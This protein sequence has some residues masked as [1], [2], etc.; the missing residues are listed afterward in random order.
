MH[1]YCTQTIMN[2][3]FFCVTVE[4]LSN[5]SSDINKNFIAKIILSITFATK[6]VNLIYY[7][8]YTSLCTDNC[9]EN[10]INIWSSF[11][12]T[13]LFLY[14]VTDIKHSKGKGKA[15][16]LQAWSGPECSRKLRLP[17]FMTRA[18]DGGKF[19][20]LKHRPP[21]PPGNIPGTHFC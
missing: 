10:I 2:S 6:T 20:S 15:V 18:E 7:S 3:A 14:I 4:K 13:A 1:S 11:K 9:R 16:P 12:G 19:V 17:D 8:K 21:L 5:F